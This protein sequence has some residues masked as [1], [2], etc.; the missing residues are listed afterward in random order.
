MIINSRG[1]SRNTS[2]EGGSQELKSGAN[3][4]P[5][6]SKPLLSALA[7]I[8]LAGFSM[9]AHAQSCGISVGYQ[10]AVSNNISSVPSLGTLGLAALA[11]ALGILAWRKRHTLDREGGIRKWM[12]AVLLT[13][14]GILGMQG[15][16]GFIQSVRA[17]GPYEF[18]SATGGTVEDLNMAYEEPSPFI[19]ITN[20]SGKRIRISSNANPDETGTCVVGAEIAPGSSCTTQAVCGGG[21]SGGGGGSAGGGGGGSG[22]L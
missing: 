21:S 16:N 18:S 9:S 3:R 11:A 13:L 14:A 20:S 5:Y 4:R 10:A 17:A 7:A 1:I 2:H 22:G 8:G 6:F 12:P 15:G 19:T